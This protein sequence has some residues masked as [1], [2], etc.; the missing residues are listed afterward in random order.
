VRSSVENALALAPTTTID[1]A[2]LADFDEENPGEIAG[3]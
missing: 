2:A 1:L 3:S